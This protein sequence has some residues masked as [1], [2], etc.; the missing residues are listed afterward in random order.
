[1]P[2]AAWTCMLVLEK[3]AVFAGAPARSFSCVNASQMRL[4]VLLVSASSFQ[5]YPCSVVSFCS[6]VPSVA[7]L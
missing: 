1:M 4:Y 3:V 2:G 6:S 7:G 5:A